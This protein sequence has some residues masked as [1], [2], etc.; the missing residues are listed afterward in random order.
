[1]AGCA[2]PLVIAYCKLTRSLW[3]LLAGGR[4]GHLKRV[5]DILGQWVPRTEVS[6]SAR[7]AFQ[8]TVLKNT[9][10]APAAALTRVTCPS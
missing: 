6:C 8:P 2:R 3:D 7:V 1:M 4:A 9:N 5:T 10:M